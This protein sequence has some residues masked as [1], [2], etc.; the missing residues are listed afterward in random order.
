M[1]EIFKSRSMALIPGP[2]SPGT[3]A[4]R[5]AA[6]A[7]G[8]SGPG[9]GPGC[10]HPVRLAGRDR[11]AVG[12]G[13]GSGVASVVGSGV[14]SWANAGASDTTPSIAM[15]KRENTLTPKATVARRWSF[16]ICMS[17]LASLTLRP[18]RAGGNQTFGVTLEGPAFPDKVRTGW[19]V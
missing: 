18:R 7:P 17:S 16:I 5:H 15:R 11:R 19:N 9:H 8:H 4:H 1:K 2:P 3:A 14:D 10:G 12:S 6:W 13:V